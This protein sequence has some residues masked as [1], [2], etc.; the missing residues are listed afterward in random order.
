MMDY[1]TMEPNREL[2]A[3]PLNLHGTSNRFD[4]KDEQMRY[5]WL[6]APLLPNAG[7]VEEPLTIQLSRL[8]LYLSQ[9]GISQ[10]NEFYKRE[11]NNTDQFRQFAV[12]LVTAGNAEVLRKHQSY[13]VGPGE[14]YLIQIG[15]RTVWKTGAAGFLHKRYVHI[16]GALLE[17][18]LR[19][20]NL[21]QQVHIKPDSPLEMYRLMKEA[22]RVLAGGSLEENMTL[23]F[24]ILVTLNRYARTKEYPRAIRLAL[25]Y[26]DR[27]SHGSYYGPLLASEAG[28]STSHLNYLFNRQFG[29]SPLAYFLRLKTEHAKILLANGQLTVKEIA[30]SLGYDDPYF[31]SRQFK[32]L[33][34][35]SPSRYRSDIIAGERSL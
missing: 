24:K 2:P 7:R 21:L 10:S 23:A 25:A 4:G 20:T 17:A 27:N 16:E 5:W 3:Q 9:S 22:N 28:V 34:G 30:A 32:S 12:E 15:S 33:T 18:M 8:P 11:R 1:F 19:A 13:T 6:R 14:V 31:F 26:M 35:S 29:V